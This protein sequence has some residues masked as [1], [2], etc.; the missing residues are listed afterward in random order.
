VHWVQDQPETSLLK[1]IACSKEITPSQGKQCRVI[2][3][4]QNLGKINPMFKTRLR[5]KEQSTAFLGK[6][7]ELSNL[8]Q[9]Y[10]SLQADCMLPDF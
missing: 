5:D 4:W 2:Q 10:V 8:V 7:P 9:M 3:S 6:T 1:N